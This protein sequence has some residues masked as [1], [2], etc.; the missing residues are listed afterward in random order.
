MSVLQKGID[1]NPVIVSV[2]VAAATVCTGA[3]LASSFALAIGAE[4]MIVA[5]RNAALSGA[6]MGFARNKAAKA[7]YLR[8]M[9]DIEEK[10]LW[11]VKE[12]AQRLSMSEQALR[13]ILYKGRGPKVTRNGR[14]V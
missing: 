2:F 14:S 1:D 11:T 8:F 7:S 10:L 9:I 13:D 4:S 12:T 3:V 5:P 6:A